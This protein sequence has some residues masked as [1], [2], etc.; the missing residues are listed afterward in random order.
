MA[1]TSL[2]F[3]RTAILILDRTSTSTG[4]LYRRHTHTH[5]DFLHVMAYVPYLY[6][7]RSSTRTYVQDLLSRSQPSTGTRSIFILWPFAMDY[8]AF[9]YNHI[10]SF[11]SG[12]APIEKL[13]GLFF[14]CK[15]VNQARVWGCPAFVLDLRLQDGNRIPK[16][17]MKAWCGQF[18]G[19]STQHSSTIRLIHNLRTGDISPQWHVVYDKL[20]ETVPSAGKDHEQ[21]LGL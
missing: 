9:L 2:V 4:L 18:L 7:L 6:Y 12:R 3:R 5:Q 1:Y 15:V 17:A 20:F 8:S 16:F 13:S 11:K 21:L 14:N 19:F 10:P